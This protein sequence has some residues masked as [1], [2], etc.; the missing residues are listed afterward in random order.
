[1]DEELHESHS[2]LLA[3]AYV[4]AGVDEASAMGDSPPV[5]VAVRRVA[6]THVVAESA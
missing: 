6:V 5:S 4:L 2:A 1:M 3:G